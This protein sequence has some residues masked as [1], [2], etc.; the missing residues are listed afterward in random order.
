MSKVLRPPCSEAELP[1]H[2]RQLPVALEMCDVT[3]DVIGPQPM[4]DSEPHCSVDDDGGVTS[5][6]KT[7]V[8]SVGK[9]SDPSTTEASEPSVGEA[10]EA[11][12]LSAGEASEP[13]SGEASQPLCTADD[14]AE[15]R[16]TAG[17][18]GGDGGDESRCESRRAAVDGGDD[19][20][21]DGTGADGGDEPLCAASDGGDDAADDGSDEPLG[22]PSEP[23]SSALMP[24]Q[25]SSL[26]VLSELS[27]TVLIVA[28]HLSRP[29]SSVPRGSELYRSAPSIFASSCTRGEQHRLRG[30]VAVDAVVYAPR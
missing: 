1:L 17:K 15:L 9:A 25:P 30:R 16:S 3:R 5:A 20:T 24:L 26:F 14:G 6:G 29:L 10:S 8:A 18:D 27:S 22:D 21:D 13:S 19:T 23:A 4:N 11:F 2:E 7:P 28:L 12:E